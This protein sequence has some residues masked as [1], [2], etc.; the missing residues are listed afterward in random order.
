L[1]RDWIPQ[2][3]LKGM[4]SRGCLAQGGLRA[5]RSRRGQMDLRAILDSIHS[6]S[7]FRARRGPKEGLLRIA[8]LGLRRLIV[9]AKVN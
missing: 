3:L 1:V 4:M 8:P 7:I 9:G 5:F 6:S 2:L